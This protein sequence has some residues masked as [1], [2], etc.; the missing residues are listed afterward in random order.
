M[1]ELRSW[2]HKNQ[3]KNP[4]TTSYGAQ[5]IAP[6]RRESNALHGWRH[7]PSND[8]NGRQDAALPM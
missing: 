6:G 3:S 8:Q 7:I 1:I 5:A 2:R 4:V